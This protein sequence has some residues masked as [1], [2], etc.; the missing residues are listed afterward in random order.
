MHGEVAAL[1]AHPGFGR[2]LVQSA[3]FILSTYSGNRL[4]NRVLNDRG[5]LLFCFL[6][7]Y[8]DALPEE[9]GGGLTVGRMV[10]LC[11]ETGVCSRG[12]AKAMMAL[13]RWGGYLEALPPA[14]DRRVKPLVPTAHMRAEFRSR[15]R[16][17]LGFLAGVDAVAGRAL[18][19]LDEEA[20]FGALAI[21]FIDGF[22]AGFRVLRF[23]PDFSLISDRDGGALVLISLFLAGRQGQVPPSVADLARQFHI[24]R[25]QVL[26]ILKDCGAEG[27]LEREGASGAGRL[28]SRGEEAIADFFASFLAY[29]LHVSRRALG[30]A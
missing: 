26:Q 4:L 19:R 14:G 29:Y 15:W 20:F 17:Q 8:L 10:G 24:S 1:R 11:Q 7:L 9:A 21:A 30:E 22:R 25:A 18:A 13:M 12:R 27:L 28:T 6:V 2:V 3:D 16:A 5:R 23:A